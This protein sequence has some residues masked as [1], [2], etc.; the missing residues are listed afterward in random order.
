VEEWNDGIIRLFDHSTMEEM[1]ERGKN[2]MMEDWKIG[3][4]KIYN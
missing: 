2:G 3:K 4:M 1:I